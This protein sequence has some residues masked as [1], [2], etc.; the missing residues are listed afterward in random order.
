[1]STLQTTNVAHARPGS[2][3]PEPKS[4]ALGSMSSHVGDITICSSSKVSPLP[5]HL[6]L[7]TLP[8]HPDRPLPLLA[9]PHACEACHTIR[10][11]SHNRIRELASLM[12]AIKD[13]ETL[14]ELRPTGKLEGSH[15]GRAHREDQRTSREPAII[16][17]SQETFYSVSACQTRKYSLTSYLCTILYLL[18]TYPPH[19][20]R[21]PDHDAKYSNEEEVDKLSGVR[22]RSSRKEESSSRYRTKRAHQQMQK[23]GDGDRDF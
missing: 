13:P 4:P 17:P 23:D 20:L 16:H 19:T 7:H 5:D 10:E 22:R 1:V 2:P 8:S 12:K 14:A 15:Q 21:D 9:Q 18:P 3:R 6:P 11:Q